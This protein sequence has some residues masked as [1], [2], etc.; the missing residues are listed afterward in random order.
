MKEV[1]IAVARVATGEVCLTVQTPSTGFT[2]GRPKNLNILLSKELAR[3]LAA[4]IVE[5]AHD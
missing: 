2:R 1:E 5:A 3:H 4:Q